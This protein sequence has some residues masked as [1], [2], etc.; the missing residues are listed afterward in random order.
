ML[1]GSLRSEEPLRSLGSLRVS[2]VTGFAGIA[3]VKRVVGATVILYIKHGLWNGEWSRF[4][5]WE[6]LLLF[7]VGISFT[8][9]EKMQ[10]SN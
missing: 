8:V 2:E 6:T 9:L 10:L 1:L 3:G 7:L 4:G 5:R